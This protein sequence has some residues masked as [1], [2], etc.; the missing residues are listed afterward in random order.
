MHS[1]SSTV[2]SF[3]LRGH[4]RAGPVVSHDHVLSNAARWR[5]TPGALDRWLLVVVDGAVQATLC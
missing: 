1:S 2:N 5:V 4:V 3:G